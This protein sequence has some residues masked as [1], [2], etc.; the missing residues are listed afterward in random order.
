MQPSPRR[1]DKTLPVEEYGEGMVC[2]PV[3]LAP[4][5]RKVRW[6]NGDRLEEKNQE[7]RGGA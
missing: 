7:A 3:C 1:H 4:L 2:C 6:S 5:Y